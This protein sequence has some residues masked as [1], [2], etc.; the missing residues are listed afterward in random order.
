MDLPQVFK[1]KMINAGREATFKY[2][3]RKTTG[4]VIH[5]N[6]LKDARLAAIKYPPETGNYQNGT[7]TTDMIKFWRNI[8]EGPEERTGIDLGGQGSAGS[9]SGSTSGGNNAQWWLIFVVQIK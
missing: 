4:F 6:N 1:E 9:S 2:G 5:K 3:K 7:C 8:P